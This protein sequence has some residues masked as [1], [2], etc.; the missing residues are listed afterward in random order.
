MHEFLHHICSQMFCHVL[1]FLLTT[2]NAAIHCIPIL[3]ITTP[4]YFYAVFVMFDQMKVTHLLNFVYSLTNTYTHTIKVQ[5][6]S[7]SGSCWCV[8]RH[9]YSLSCLP[10]WLH[11]VHF[12]HAVSVCRHVPHDSWC[13]LSACAPGTHSSR[14]SCTV[15]RLPSVSPGVART[16][17]LLVRPLGVRSWHAV[18]SRGDSV[19]LC[20]W[21]SWL[22]PAPA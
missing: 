13:G 10:A 21:L 14:A 16:L 20:D 17:R 15:P 8:A 19:I 12:R 9:Q 5:G 6:T 2:V 4:E 18:L 11:G 3:S 1:A 7:S 22:P